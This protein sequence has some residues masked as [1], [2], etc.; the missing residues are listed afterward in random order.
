MLYLSEGRPTL[1]VWGAL[2][3]V[4]PVS[5]AYDAHAM[6]PG[7][8][9]EIFEQSEHFPHMDE[10]DRFA[11]VLLR[12]LASTEPVPIDR[13]LLRQRMATRSRAVAAQ[14]AADKLAAAHVA[15]DY[16]AADQ[17]AADQAAA[18]EQAAAQQ[19]A[20]DAQP[21]RARPAPA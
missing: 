13:A 6:I 7:S 15:A 4:I 8:Q 20:V 12:F 9:L 5:H 19:A 2:D 11:R 16:V 3:T 18:D 21:D 14:V 1:I 10:P 17:L